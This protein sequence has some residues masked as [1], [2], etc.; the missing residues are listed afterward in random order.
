M[1]DTFVVIH[2]YDVES[3]TSHINSI[4]PH[5]KFTIEPEKD[6]LLLFLDTEIILNDDATTD[7]RVY[8]KPSHTDQY[9]NWSSNHPIQ[10][11]RSVARTLL[12]RAE[13]TPSNQ[14]EK[15]K[16]MNHI[17]EELQ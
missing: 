3:F 2:E 11:K 10:H 7:T 15:E 13:I 12:E 1:D 9:L 17:K 8:R 14:K 16:E 4:D 6:N 5:I